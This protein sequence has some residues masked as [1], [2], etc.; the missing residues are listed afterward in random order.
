MVYDEM[1]KY[2]HLAY[3]N[4]GK[5]IEHK[6][7]NRGMAQFLIVRHVCLL[8]KDEPIHVFCLNMK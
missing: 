7:L 6:I 5:D 1:V 8:R 3:H 2:S 4:F